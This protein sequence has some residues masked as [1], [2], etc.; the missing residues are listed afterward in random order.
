MNTALKALGIGALIAIGWAGA[1]EAIIRTC[2][3]IGK[4]KEMA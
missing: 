1:V 4:I 3:L 2:D